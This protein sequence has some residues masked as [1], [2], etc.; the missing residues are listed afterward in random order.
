MRVFG[1][2]LSFTFLAIGC[3]SN[4]YEG[5]QPFSAS[6]I[7]LYSLTSISGQPVEET[8]VVQ[9]QILEST[10]TG[11]SAIDRCSSIITL[12]TSGVL[13]SDGRGSAGCYIDYGPDSPHNQIVEGIQSSGLIER[14]GRIFIG[15]YEFSPTE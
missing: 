1:S 6:S 11:L 5:P 12:S 13:L 2:I 4:P 15:L 14:D 9:L 7:G 8:Q 10:A 3:G